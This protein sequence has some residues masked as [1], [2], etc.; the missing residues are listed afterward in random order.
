MSSFDKDD[1]RVPQPPQLAGG[2]LPQADSGQTQVTPTPFAI[3]TSIIP[4]IERLP[5]SDLERPDRKAAFLQGLGS[6]AREEFQ[7]ALEHLKNWIPKPH[8]KFFWPVVLEVL[9]TPEARQSFASR[10]TSNAQ[11]EATFQETFL[12]SLLETA[13]SSSHLGHRQ[14]R[15]QGRILAAMAWWAPQA[16]SQH[17]I[18]AIDSNE[19]VLRPFA[20]SMAF[21]GRLETND[22]FAPSSDFCRHLLKDISGVLAGND[23]DLEVLLS[24]GALQLLSTCCTDLDRAK[25]VLHGQTQPN[26]FSQSSAP[27]SLKLFADALYQWIERNAHNDSEDF[28]DHIAR[29]LHASLLTEQIAA[30]IPSDRRYRWAPEY[31]DLFQTLLSFSFRAEFSDGIEISKNLVAGKKDTNLTPSQTAALSYVGDELASSPHGELSKHLASPNTLRAFLTAPEE[32][33]R[34]AQKVKEV[35]EE[36]AKRNSPVIETFLSKARLELL[37]W[38]QSHPPAMG[39][40]KV[41]AVIDTEEKATQ[42]LH[43]WKKQ[44]RNESEFLDTMAAI[45]PWVKTA[46]DIQNSCEIWYERLLQERLRSLTH[47]SRWYRHTE[48]SQVDLLTHFL[49]QDTRDKPASEKLAGIAAALNELSPE[50]DL[51]I[52]LRLSA[53]SSKTGLWLEPKDEL[54]TCRSF[55]ETFGSIYRPTLY[56][57]FRTL[58]AGLSWKE[59]THVEDLLAHR[60]N[61]LSK[62]C[63]NDLHTECSDPLELE[64]LDHIC[65][66]KSNTFG[67]RKV[68]LTTIRNWDEVTKTRAHAYAAALD[69]SL[70]VGHDRKSWREQH[71]AAVRAQSAWEAF[72]RVGPKTTNLALRNSLQ[73]FSVPEVS[74]ALNYLNALKEPKGVFTTGYDELA[75]ILG[76]KAIFRKIMPSHPPPAADRNDEGAS[77]QRKLL[78]SAI[79]YDLPDSLTREQINEY[80]IWISFMTLRILFS[81]PAPGQKRYLRYNEA[82][83]QQ[84]QAL[85]W[86]DIGAGL[87]QGTLADEY[88]FRDIDWSAERRQEF[89][90]RL[91]AALPYDEMIEALEQHSATALSHPVT[92]DIKQSCTLTMIPTRGIAR[93]LSGHLFDVCWANNEGAFRSVK[94]VDDGRPNIIAVTFVRDYDTPKATIVGG[95]LVV[96]GYETDNP[97]QPVMI[98][99]GC[100]PRSAFLNQTY[101]GEVFDQWISYLSEVANAGEM[102][103]AIPADPVPFLALTNQPGL[104]YY[105][106]N[107]YFSGSRLNVGSVA[108]TEFNGIRVG[109]RLRHIAHHP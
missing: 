32:M 26:L 47:Q 19:R 35:I 79:E 14:L 22:Y 16:L 67:E 98:I 75:T 8:Q 53:G 27:S 28:R 59:F 61:L 5:L 37:S 7:F 13:N 71:T 49:P 94:G 92:S 80:R 90:K 109:D 55:V 81:P 63:E 46:E 65:H 96:I 66:L 43:I 11:H 3:V 48:L 100:N 91:R 84:G 82:L 31:R 20:V 97:Q 4:S 101:V 30:S 29:L 52:Y 10:I 54:L 77:W 107:N 18:K 42:F 62:I 104:F 33:P 50:E 74:F 99:R 73:R 87:F 83:D 88:I 39:W 108:L 76:S 9:N 57:A 56:D 36:E 12:K 58:R 86:A 21:I 106:R 70:P 51:A 41:L 72:T 24:A 34:L 15:C 40:W 64:L 60:L 85:L 6:Q 102:K 105:A 69:P 44:Q 95:S 103:I 2:R 38:A 89:L 68:A 93:E 1:K 78:R 25:D 23:S 17:L 45:L